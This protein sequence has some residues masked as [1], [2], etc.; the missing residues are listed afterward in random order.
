MTRS[1][2]AAL[3]AAASLAACAPDPKPPTAVPVVTV[4]LAAPRSEEK[5]E[6]L[7]VAAQD[8]PPGPAIK[9]EKLGAADA[10]SAPS[11][12][13]VVGRGKLSITPG[14]VTVVAFW[15]TWCAPCQKSFP[16]LQ[17]LSI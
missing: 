13:A 8:E 4:A 16:K 7:E 14:K 5:K 1:P 6:P 11:P 17:A 9:E 2:I 12:P 10:A 3:A 15:A